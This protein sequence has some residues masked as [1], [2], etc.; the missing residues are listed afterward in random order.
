MYISLDPMHVDSLTVTVKNPSTFISAIDFTT[1][2]LIDSV[3]SIE[4]PRQLTMAMAETALA[5]EKN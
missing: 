2:V 5:V 3:S 1:T 4:M